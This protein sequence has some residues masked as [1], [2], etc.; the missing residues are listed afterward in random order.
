MPDYLTTRTAAKVAGDKHYH[1]DKK[2]IR[3]HQA[4]RFTSTGGCT[5]CNMENMAVDTVKTV[6]W[7]HPDDAPK[8]RAVADFLRNKRARGDS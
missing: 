7:T 2:C 5:A 4:P 8:I 6:L 3:G 1:T